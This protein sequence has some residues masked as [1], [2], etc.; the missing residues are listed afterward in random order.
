MKSFYWDI[1][2]GGITLQSCYN[3]GYQ[4]PWG[5]FLVPPLGLESFMGQLYVDLAQ[6][7]A[8]KSYHEKVIEGWV[9]REWAE[10]VYDFKNLNFAKRIS[11]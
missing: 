1:V 8:E 5:F 10:I 6:Y 2:H 11:V 9:E 3:S 7:G 4:Q